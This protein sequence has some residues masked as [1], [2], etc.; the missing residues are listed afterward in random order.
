MTQSSSGESVYLEQQCANDRKLQK[1]LN[2]TSIAVSQRKVS[3]QGLDRLHE[4][5]LAKLGLSF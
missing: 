5:A 3:R 1:G 4:D 2:L